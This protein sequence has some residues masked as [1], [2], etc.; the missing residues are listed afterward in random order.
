METPMTV[1]S[2]A[3][4]GV[5]ERDVGRTKQLATTVFEKKS[6]GVPLMRCH[7]IRVVVHRFGPPVRRPF[8]LQVIRFLTEIHFQKT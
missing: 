6:L 5:L 7:V 8:R 1:A 4:A 2:V 3:V